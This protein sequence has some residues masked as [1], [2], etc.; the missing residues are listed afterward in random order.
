MKIAF[1]RFHVAKH[2]GDAVDK[3]RREEYRTLAGW[4]RWLEWASGCGLDPVL[5]AARMIRQHLWESSPRDHPLRPPRT[6]RRHHSR[7][8]TARW[9][10]RT[11]VTNGLAG[12]TSVESP[13]GSK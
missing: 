10:R 12:E 8:K 3:V 4:H 1:D 5:K 7:I 2:L 9:H 6:G 11:T 13:A